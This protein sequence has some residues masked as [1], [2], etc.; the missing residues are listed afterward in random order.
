MHGMVLTYRGDM[1]TMRHP[2]RL[3]HPY[4]C[5]ATILEK[6]KGPMDRHDIVQSYRPCSSAEASKITETW[7]IG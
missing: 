1:S 3:V 5:A 6:D 2:L 7:L 4:K